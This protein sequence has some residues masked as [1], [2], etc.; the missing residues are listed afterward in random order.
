MGH[1]T[2][3]SFGAVVL[4][5]FGN[6]LKTR[7]LVPELHRGEGRL[8]LMTREAGEQRGR[9]QPGREGGRAP[10]GLAA[11]RV[12]W[13]YPQRTC[14]AWG[15]GTWRRCRQMLSAS[16]L[17]RDGAG[18]TAGTP[19]SPRTPWPPRGIPALPGTPPARPA[20]RVSGARPGGLC[21]VPP[22]LSP[23]VGPGRPG[24]A[25]QPKGR[26][27]AL[28][29]TAHAGNPSLRRAGRL[30]LPSAE[31]GDAGLPWEPAPHPVPL[32]GDS[33][34]P[35]PPTHTCPRSSASQ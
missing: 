25:V 13:G 14:Q 33:D 23:A 19:S 29:I 22:S 18:S 16:S 15:L 3:G 34:H 20:A 27:G 26:A 11:P 7:P 28:P 5:G 24:G 10:T 31:G 4:G 35:C 30:L 2:D 9:L 6:W 17:C 1:P 12:G 32:W 21:W 8:L